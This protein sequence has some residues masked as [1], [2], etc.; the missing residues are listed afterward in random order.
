MLKI[1]LGLDRLMLIAEHGL[2]RALPELQG[3]GGDFG[4]G[5]E[6][7]A[8]PK[9]VAAVIVRNGQLPRHKSRARF[10]SRG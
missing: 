10:L 8:D 3:A 2:V 5:P 4:I 7:I 9:V 1:R 6:H